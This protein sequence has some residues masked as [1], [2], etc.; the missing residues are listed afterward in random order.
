M[1]LHAYASQRF[2]NYTASL[3]MTW[4]V[5]LTTTEFLIES[6]PILNR[7]LWINRSCKVPSRGYGTQID[8]D[9]PMIVEVT[10]KRER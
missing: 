7:G 9:V 10:D 3:G 5:I 2:N 4:R 1:K 8:D 6:T